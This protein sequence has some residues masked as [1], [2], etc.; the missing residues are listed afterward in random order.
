M[1]HTVRSFCSVGDHLGGGTALSAFNLALA[2]APQ[3]LLLL[4][5]VVVVVFGLV[6]VFVLVFVWLITS[7]RLWL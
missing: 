7:Q 2:P 4:L 1:G 3:L 5:L 6:L